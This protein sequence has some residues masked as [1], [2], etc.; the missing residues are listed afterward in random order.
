MQLGFEMK[1]NNMCTIYLDNINIA[2][3]PGNPLSISTTSTK[4]SL[5]FFPNPA[6]DELNVNYFLAAGISDP[7][8]AIYDAAGKLCFRQQLS[9]DQKTIK[10]NISK[11]PEGLFF[12]TIESG[13]T[14]L[15]SGKFSI[16]R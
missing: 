6:N 7:V 16:V 14:V 12:C 11:L 8:I 2:S 9:P 4:N 15:K 1:G 3:G 10:L 5:L 13:N